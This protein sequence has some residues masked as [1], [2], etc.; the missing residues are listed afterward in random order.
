VEGSEHLV[1]RWVDGTRR[2]FLG[3]EPLERLPVRLVELGAEEG[4]LIR[5]HT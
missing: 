4:V 5:R 3:D 1:V 2:S